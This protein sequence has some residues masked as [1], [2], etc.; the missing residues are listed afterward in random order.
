MRTVFNVDKKGD[1]Y[2][3]SGEIDIYD[4]EEFHRILD[5]LLPKETILL[6]FKEVVSMDAAALQLLV[7]F[8]KSLPKKSTFKIIGLHPS[9]E[10]ILTISG[11]GRYLI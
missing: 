1:V 8:R 6:D 11:L 7:S 9:L 5:E 2:K 3:F 10:K 4:L